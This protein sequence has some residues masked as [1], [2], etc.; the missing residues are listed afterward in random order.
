L[1]NVCL[2]GRLTRDPELRHTANETPVCNFT[3]AVDRRFKSDGQPTADFINIIAWQN[4]AEFVEKWFT[5]GMR[6]FA[7]GRIQTRNWE[8]RDGNKRYSTEV[9]ADQ[10][11]FADGKRGDSAPKATEEIDDSDFPF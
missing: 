6:V 1:N 10:V 11:G 2:V 5:K 9:V 3:L 7:V 8:D 4:T